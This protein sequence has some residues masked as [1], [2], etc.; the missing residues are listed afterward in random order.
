VTKPELGVKRDCPECRARFYDLNKEPAHCPKCGH[1]FIPEALLK[2]RRPR[3]E[4]EVP[5]KQEAGKPAPE[6]PLDVVDKEQK[7]P[8]SN[9]KP[10]LDED[11]GEPGEEDIEDIDVDLEVEIEDDSDDDAILEE[12]EDDD[13]MSTIVSPGGGGEER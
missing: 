3:R 11:A 5:E 9:R 2:P 7:A 13:D 8:T 4:D 1:E 12:D 6:A 10:A